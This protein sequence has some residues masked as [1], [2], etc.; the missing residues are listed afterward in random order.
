MAAWSNQLLQA[1][2][3]MEAGLCPTAS[4]SPTRQMGSEEIQT[5]TCKTSSVEMAMDNRKTRSR[6]LCTLAI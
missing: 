4:Q 3:S 1:V 6:A 5:A 2:L